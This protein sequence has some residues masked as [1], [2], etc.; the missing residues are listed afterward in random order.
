MKKNKVTSQE[1]DQSN[2]IRKRLKQLLKKQTKSP[3]YEKD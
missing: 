1:R 3:S 2:F